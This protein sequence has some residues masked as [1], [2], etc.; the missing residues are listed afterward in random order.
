MYYVNGGDGR[1]CG[2]PDD[3][4]A[5]RGGAAGGG[6]GGAPPN[7]FLGPAVEQGRPVHLLRDAQQH[8]R[9]LQPDVARG[10]QIGVLDRETGRTFTKTNAVGSGMRPE[11]SPDG[12]WLA[13]AT[14]NNAETSL[15]LRDL[16]TGDER[17][18]LPKIQRDDQESRPNRDVV[19]TYAFT[20]DSRS[21]VIGHHGHFW[22]A[23]VAD[24]HETMI[25]FTADVDMMIAGPTKETYRDRTIRRSRC[26][27]SATSSP[28]PDNKRLAFVALDRLWIM[29]LPNGT[30][31]RARAVGERRRVPADLVAR[32]TV[33][34]LRH[35]ERR[36]RRHGVARSQPTAPDARRS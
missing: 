28:S 17:L 30:P 18:L 12:K 5:G 19:P 29:D 6:R 34:R 23:N 26:I 1:A 13:Y 2:S 4:A 35:V 27:R 15:M 24:G 11:L 36:R 22:R 31:H 25:P 14:R 16:A 21:I 32:R 9:R 33:H 10:W 3:T 8:R 20:P 7:V